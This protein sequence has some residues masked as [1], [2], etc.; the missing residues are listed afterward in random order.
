[1]AADLDEIT[2]PDTTGPQP[3]LSDSVWSAG[4]SYVIR[5]S[6]STTVK[7][8]WTEFCLMLDGLVQA[9]IE[10]RHGGLVDLD[11]AACLV[12]RDGSACP[13]ARCHCLDCR[14]L[15]TSATFSVKGR[16]VSMT[17]VAV[18]QGENSASRRVTFGP[19]AG[20]VPARNRTSALDHA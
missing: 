18:D 10:N 9:R 12:I 20:V 7:I 1:M 5:E 13:A 17:S 6:R 15:I 16:L 14:S 2:G 19:V 3:A 11:R 4:S 8:V